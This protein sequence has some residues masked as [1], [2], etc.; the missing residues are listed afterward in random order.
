M[1]SLL[2]D[3]RFLNVKFH[4]QYPIGPYIVDFC[5]RRKRLVIEIDGGGHNYLTQ[6]KK[7]IRRDIYLKRCGYRVIRIWSSEVVNNIEGVT[8][9]IIEALQY[10][11]SS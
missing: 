7:D 3:R 1:W 11:P 9:A 4:R 5:C 8:E 10:R 2:R 6:R